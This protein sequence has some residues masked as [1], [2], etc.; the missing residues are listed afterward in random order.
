MNIVIVG[1]GAIGLLWYRY[2]SL[3]LDNNVALI[4]SRNIK[5]PPTHFTFTNL[6]NKSECIKLAVASSDSTTSVENADIIL[7]CVK[8]FQVV[9]AIKQLPTLNNSKAVIMLCHNGMGITEQLTE[10][11]AK[12]SPG[13]NKQTPTVLSMLLTHGAKLNAA[14]DVIHTGT[15]KTDIG[16]VCGTLNDNHQQQLIATINS[17]L[18][19]VYWQENIKQQQWEKLAINCVI[20]PITAINQIKNGDVNHSQYEHVKKTTIIELVTIAKA[21]GIELNTE[22]LLKTVH[23]V[24]SLT[25]ENSSS[26]R[27]D[28]LAARRTE[29]DYINGYIHQLGIKHHIPTPQNSLFCQQIKI[30]EQQ[31]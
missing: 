24:A 11:L 16:L 8:A 29:I 25:A 21:E 19:V 22:A 20:N 28:L 7:I 18:P 17:A 6:D 12:Q 31:A 27:S 2:L 15:G 1:Q 5:T 23:Q 14:F 4:C 10:K 9:E 3:Q 30:L 26:M 13:S